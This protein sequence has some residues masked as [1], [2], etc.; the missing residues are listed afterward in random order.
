MS[1]VKRAVVGMLCV[2]LLVCSFIAF[3]GFTSANAE[4]SEYFSAEE[5]TQ[6]DHLLNVDGSL[7]SKT[8][9]TFAEDV[10]NSE[11]A[12]FIPD[13]SR[14]VP[15]QYLE[16][17]GTYSYFGKEYGFYMVVE[18]PYIDLLLVDISYELEEGKLY[19]E[20]N[21]DNVY[22]MKIQPILQQSFYIT[23][24]GKGNLTWQKYSTVNRPVYYIM[25]P[26]F[27]TSISNE[28]ALNQG[29]PYYSKQ[30]DEGII[31]QQTMVEYQRILQSRTVGLEIIP[32]FL[33]SMALDAVIDTLDSAIFGGFLGF[34]QSAIDFAAGHCDSRQNN[35]FFTGET[36]SIFTE[37]AKETQKEDDDREGYSRT[38]YFYPEEEIFLSEFE[39]SYAEFSVLVSNTDYKT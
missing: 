25:N 19:G 1:N 23:K 7:S 4:T 22:T 17:D 8:I 35:N 13:L 15:L 26:R 34:M 28:N 27:V 29:D 10:H 36:I 24:D 11:M 16:N 33:A 18:E 20:H 31:I 2:I 39:E 37:Q 14:V 21:K 32:G 9:F 38:T 6:D 5:Y 3:T 12:A 30:E